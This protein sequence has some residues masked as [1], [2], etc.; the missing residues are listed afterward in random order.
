MGGEWILLIVLVVMLVA[1]YAFSFTRKKKYNDSLTS[2]RDEL[3]KGDKVL[4]DSG[5]VG[6]VVESYEEDGYK[7]FVLKT[8]KGEN[9]SFITVH[10]NA[11]YHVFDKPSKE[12]KLTNTKVVK[13]EKTET[14]KVE[15]NTETTENKT[16]EVKENKPQK[17]NKNK[18]KNRRK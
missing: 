12:V 5:V 1:M 14:A 8:G 10:G 17:S 18:S 7:Y 11:I 3:K 4:T 15:E 13:E 9:S 6:S 2:M 16:E